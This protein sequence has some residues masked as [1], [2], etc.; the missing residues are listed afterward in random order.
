MSH[1]DTEE[2]LRPSRYQEEA[3]NPS[4]CLKGGREDLDQ[5]WKRSEPENRN[6]KPLFQVTFSLHVSLRCSLMDFT[7]HQLPHQEAQP[8]FHE[9]ETD[10]IP[11]SQTF[12]KLIKWSL[13]N[14]LSVHQCLLQNIQLHELILI[15]YFSLEIS[16]LNLIFFFFCFL[17]LVFPP[18][19]KKGLWSNVCGGNIRSVLINTETPRNQLSRQTQITYEI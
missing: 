19:W 16:V 5:W 14:T 4:G 13:Y 8:S 9:T 6:I 1:L 7:R 15:I 10:K 18:Q 3:F 12:P 2:V 17:L 11:F